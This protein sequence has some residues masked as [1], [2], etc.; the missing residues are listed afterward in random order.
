MEIIQVSGRA[1]R[2]GERGWARNSRQ[3]RNARSAG[4]A[5]NAA[6]SAMLERIGGV[7][8]RKRRVAGRTGLLGESGERMK[9]VAG[10]VAKEVNIGEQ[11]GAT[12]VAREGNRVHV[13]G[14]EIGRSELGGGARGEVNLVAGV[15]RSEGVVVGDERGR[16]LG[17]FL[18]FRV[19]NRIVVG[20]A[21]VSMGRMER[22]G[23]VKRVSHSIGIGRLFCEVLATSCV[24]CDSEV[25]R[26]VLENAL[27]N[28][29][30]GFVHKFDNKTISVGSYEK[31][32]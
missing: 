21:K 5:G 18:H 23:S 14:G 9:Q 13:L 3:R 17:D 1:R 31:R 7:E 24:L 22:L 16:E 28:V 27:Q 29:E 15:H 32:T 8:A 6:G 10:A 4:N 12:V 30:F 26:Q 25:A 20:H 2:S 11:R 19:G